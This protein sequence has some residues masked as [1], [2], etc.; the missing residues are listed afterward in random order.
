MLTIVNNVA[1]PTYVG[2]C[3]QCN[4]VFTKATQARLRYSEVEVYKNV[5]VVTSSQTGFSHYEISIS[6]LAVNII[7]FP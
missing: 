3:A 1:P 6:Q 7:P 2:A 5:T 4:D